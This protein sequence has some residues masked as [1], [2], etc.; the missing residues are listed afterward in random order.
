MGQKG[1]KVMK[2]GFLKTKDKIFP[3]MVVLGITNV[4]NNRCIMCPYKQIIKE[5][6]YKPEFMKGALYKK[7]I[8]EIAKHPGTVLRLTPDGEVLLHPKIVEYVKYAK[9][10][11]I[12]TISFDTN[13]LALDKEKA[14]G[15]LRAGLDLINISL[16]AFKKETYLK[17]RQGS[18][19]EKVMVNTHR[20]IELRNKGEYKTKITVSIVDQPEVAS[21]IEDFITYWSQRVDRVIRRKYLGCMG[22]VGK[23][24]EGF[25]NV[26]RW[27]CKFIFTRT[28]IG[29][30]GIMR[31][32]ND[33]WYEQT[34]VGDLKF[35]SIEEVWQSRRYQQV[36]EHHLKSKY[37]KEAYCRNCTEWQSAEWNYDYFYVLNK[38]LRAK[39]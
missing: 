14:I 36:R 3:P 13:A 35:Q 7:I 8:D 6:W 1:K 23:E 33:D 25:K 21:E 34:V 15:L 10:K 29:P 20:F 12:K 24:K 38:V 17:V 32:C 16:D 31:F 5:N 11:G 2:Y 39:N 26:K 4:C 27:P 22:L 37:D 9:G 19:Y 30:D 28:N 18:N